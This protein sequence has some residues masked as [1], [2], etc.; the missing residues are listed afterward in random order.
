MSRYLPLP[1]VILGIACII[2]GFYVPYV[3]GSYSRGY[4]R[5]AVEI[6][7]E[8]ER[9][10]NPKAQDAAINNA[11]ES[12]SGLADIMAKASMVLGAVAGCALIF[13]A[14]LLTRTTDLNVRLNDAK[15]RLEAEISSR[16][17][18]NRQGDEERLASKSQPIN[19]RARKE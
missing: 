9:F 16:Y 15:A 18:I 10:E 4:A 14:H 19:P 17:Q 1:L 5:T 13:A 8:S 6:A 12:S 3:S 11:L 7:L 2:G